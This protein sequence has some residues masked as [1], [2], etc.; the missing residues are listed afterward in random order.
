M[1][2]SPIGD[3]VGVIW[4]SLYNATLVTIAVGGDVN[5]PNSNAQKDTDIN[6]DK[7]TSYPS[8][9]ASQTWTMAMILL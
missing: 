4:N 3:S 8:G 5:D 2:E 1:Q 7:A 6:G 9:H